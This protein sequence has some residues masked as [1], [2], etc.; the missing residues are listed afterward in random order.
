LLLPRKKFKAQRAIF[1][2][3]WAAGLLAMLALFATGTLDGASFYVLSERWD[4]SALFIF[5]FVFVLNPLGALRWKRTLGWFSIDL[6]TKDAI[7]ITM[8]G[9]FYNLF[10]PGGLGSDL[11]R[12][13]FLKANTDITAAKVA[14]SVLLDRIFGLSS[15]LL[16]SCMYLPRIL[17]EV[18]SVPVL[19]LATGSVFWFLCCASTYL[20]GHKI[21]RLQVGAIFAISL[22]NSFGAVLCIFISMAA[23]DMAASSNLMSVI[24]ATSLGNVLMGLPIAPAGIGVGHVFFETIFGQMGIS[25]GAEIFN[26]Y[27]TLC[28]VSV[29]LSGLFQFLPTNVFFGASSRC[30][31]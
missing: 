21:D 5:V 28:L 26:H 15:L 31:S 10:I 19:V 9:N 18:W 24:G 17:G 2:L 8:T 30:R 23:L 27:A 4:L 14:A 22:I 7:L 25:R 3:K 16:I 20:A 6:R 1:L 12:G 29:A 13:G 11:V